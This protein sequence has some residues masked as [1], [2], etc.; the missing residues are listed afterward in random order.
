MRQSLPERSFPEIAVDLELFASRE[1]I[2]IEALEMMQMRAPSPVIARALDECRNAAVTAAK[3][4]MLFRQWSPFEPEV[5]QVL[6]S[7]SS[8]AHALD[9]RPVESEAA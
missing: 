1:A 9:L 5:R 8:E 6:E 4:A 7:I 2:G 3:L